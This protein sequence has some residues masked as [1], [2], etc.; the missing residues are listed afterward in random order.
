MQQMHETDEWQLQQPATNPKAYSI[1]TITSFKLY[2][3]IRI[4]RTHEGLLSSN[5]LAQRNTSKRL[6]FLLHN[7]NQEIVPHSWAEPVNEPVFLV[8]LHTLV[9][10]QTEIREVKP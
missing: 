9:E 10:A 1:I 7:Y 5:S 3:L 8:A 4:V 6:K 2:K